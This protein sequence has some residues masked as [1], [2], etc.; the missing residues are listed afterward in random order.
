MKGF[1]VLATQVNSARKPRG[2]AALKARGDIEELAR[3]SRMG[4]ERAKHL[5]TA[6]RWTP[7]EARAARARRGTVSRPLHEDERSVA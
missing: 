3:I 1:I 5:G 6:H 4:A 2:F 7:T